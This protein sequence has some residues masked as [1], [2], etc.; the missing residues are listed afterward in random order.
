LQQNEEE[1]YLF[2]QKQKQNLSTNI[3]KHG[4]GFPEG[5]TPIMQDTLSSAEY[6]TSKYH[7]KKRKRTVHSTLQ[8]HVNEHTFMYQSR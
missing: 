4:G 7:K 3:R 8:E 6:D 5:H 2:C 1:E